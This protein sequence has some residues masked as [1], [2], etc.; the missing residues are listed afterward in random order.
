VVLDAVVGKD[1]AV[2]ELKAISG[3]TQLTRAAMEAVRQW[4]FRPYRPN[5]S[6]V[7]FRTEIT[8]NFTLP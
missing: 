4:R 5:G 6:P 7:A 8:L 2:Q 1:G 3:D